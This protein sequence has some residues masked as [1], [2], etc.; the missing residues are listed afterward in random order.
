[1]MGTSS[2]NH[3]Q[4]RRR[5]SLSLSTIVLASGFF[6]CTAGKQFERR[7]SGLER[8]VDDIRIVQADLTARLDSLESQSRRVT[9]KVEELEFSQTHRIG[10]DVGT[11]KRD[12]SRLQ[13]RIPPP[14]LV[15]LIPLEVDENY[16]ASL[17]P[18]EGRIFSNSLT[19]IRT[20]SYQEALPGLKQLYE[21]TTSGDL[22]ARVLF[23]M[24]V[25]EEG[26]G[27][28]PASLRAYHELSQSFPTN[29]R[30]PLALLR[31]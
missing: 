26:A 5:L 30:V 23:W 2:Y 18:E 25:C 24:A 19:R 1:M 22:G 15:P 10:D 6:G 28:N 29:E 17:P 4:F 31:Q 13:K 8:S 21:N 27:N 20:G 7:V 9:G 14:A 3:F 12:L 16:V 11:L